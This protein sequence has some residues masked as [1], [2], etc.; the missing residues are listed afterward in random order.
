MTADDKDLTALSCPKISV[1]KSLSRFLNLIFSS[2]VIFLSGILAILAITV[3]I[4]ILFTIFLFLDESILTKAAASSMTSMALSG[5]FLSLMNLVERS[6]AT[7]KHSGSYFTS[8]KS[9]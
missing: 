5:N 6:T 4:S 2:E 3:S 7:S 1:F 9:S 8:W